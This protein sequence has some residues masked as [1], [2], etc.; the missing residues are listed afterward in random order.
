ML[1]LQF[2]KLTSGLDVLQRVLTSFMPNSP[3]MVNVLVDLTGIFPPQEVLRL[4][5]K[6]MWL[7]YCC[8]VLE[9]KLLCDMPDS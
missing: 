9:L 4:E 2:N 6:V 7:L 5:Q 8:S 3:Y 1:N